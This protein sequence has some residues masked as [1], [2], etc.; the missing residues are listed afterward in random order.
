M[1]LI[2]PVSDHLLPLFFLSLEPGVQSK[3]FIF[4]YFCTKPMQ[5]YLGVPKRGFEFMKGW[6]HFLVFI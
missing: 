2:A 3:C 1:F 4:L 5:I 6:V